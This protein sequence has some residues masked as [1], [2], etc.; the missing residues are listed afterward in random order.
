MRLV[1]QA[2]SWGFEV[3]PWKRWI[4]ENKIVAEFLPIGPPLDKSL[5]WIATYLGA[6]YDFK[7]AALVG[8]WR[9]FGRWI[10][11]KFSDPSRLMCSEGVI[12]FLQYG[13]YTSVR[14]LDP[15]TT[16]PGLL[17]KILLSS[18]EFRRLSATP[19]ILKR[20]GVNRE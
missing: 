10:K 9:L 20:F 19:K 13:G 16:S 4:K 11:G 17:L 2:E 14:W 7:A 8:F 6:R 1:M 3:R 15:E 12:R 18:G 5:K